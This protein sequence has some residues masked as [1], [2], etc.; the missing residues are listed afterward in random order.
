MAP[1]T[2]EAQAP[3]ALCQRVRGA[4]QNHTTDTTRQIAAVA[5]GFV[6]RR[7]MCRDLIAKPKRQRDAG[8]DMF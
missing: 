3:G 7:L 1:T 4:S 5:P 2:D 8:S 6:G